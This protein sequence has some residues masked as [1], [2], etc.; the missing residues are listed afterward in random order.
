[1]AAI[2]YVEMEQTEIA[3]S[4]ESSDP[5]AKVVTDE[6]VQAT[7]LDTSEAEVVDSKLEIAYEDLQSAVVS[8]LQ[9]IYFGSGDHLDFRTGN[10]VYILMRIHQILGVLNSTIIEFPEKKSV[11]VGHLRNLMASISIDK[12]DTESIKVTEPTP[13]MIRFFRSYGAYFSIQAGTKASVFGAGYRRETKN[14]GVD[15]IEDSL[16][17]NFRI[18]ENEDIPGILA[19]MLCEE[20]PIIHNFASKLKVILM[21]NRLPSDERKELEWSLANQTS[22]VPEKETDEVAIAVVSTE[23]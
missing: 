22:K 3:P 21:N 7:N 18:H 2:E 17:T 20:D 8:E 9:E 5:Q 14:I 11:V 16:N 10:R 12:I 15:Y 19:S 23:G 13:T 4:V 1:M 6:V